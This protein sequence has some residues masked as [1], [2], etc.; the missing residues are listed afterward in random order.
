MKH[1]WH[2]LIRYQMSQFEYYDVC[3]LLTK[4]FIKFQFYSD[5]LYD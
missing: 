4:R 1:Y 2:I 5:F 3:K